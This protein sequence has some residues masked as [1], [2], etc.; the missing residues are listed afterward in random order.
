[1]G[2]Q[3][4]ELNKCIGSVHNTRQGNMLNKQTMGYGYQSEADSYKVY[5]AAGALGTNL[6]REN[7]LKAPAD[8]LGYLPLAGCESGSIVPAFHFGYS[9]ENFSRSRNIDSGISTLDSAQQINL[10]LN[11]DTANTHS[12]DS[13]LDT[14]AVA[15]MLICIKADGSMSTTY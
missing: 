3:L 8:S 5:N 1:M 15:D 12:Y 14:F 7:N 6:G 13:R 9:F 4:H 10:T 11:R 2:E